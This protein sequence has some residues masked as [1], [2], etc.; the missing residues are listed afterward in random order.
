MVRVTDNNSNTSDA[1]I[2]VGW[3]TSAIDSIDDV[4]KYNS[5]ALDASGKPKISYLDNTAKGLKYAQ[6]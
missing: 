4:G 3:N 5:V 1:T 6:K 2:V